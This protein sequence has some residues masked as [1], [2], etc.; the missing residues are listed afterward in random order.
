[1]LA[2]VG[3][4]VLLNWR[5]RCPGRRA[6]CIRTRGARRRS[7]AAGLHS[8]GKRHTR[9][10]RRPW[11]RLGTFRSRR[12]RC[13]GRPIA[14]RRR[15]GQGPASPDGSTW[16]PAPIV[17]QA[18]EMRHRDHA[19]QV[20]RDRAPARSPLR[21]TTGV[22]RQKSIPCR[23]GARES[24]GCRRGPA[25]PGRAAQVPVS[26]EEHGGA[27]LV[28][29][30]RSPRWLRK[31]AAVTLGSVVGRRGA[32]TGGASRRP[33]ATRPPRRSRATSPRARRARPS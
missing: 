8:R 15:R 19:R 22:L 29:A 18:P 21:R 11:R 5:P 25:T 23:T 1:M 12:C 14:C 7:R 30:G 9:G 3:R 24:P 17:Q 13:R 31:A 32:R 6:W 20:F 27:L 2:G 10:Y 26:S 4:A 28:H 16:G 33:R